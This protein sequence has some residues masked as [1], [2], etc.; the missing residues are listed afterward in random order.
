MLCY[1]YLNKNENLNHCS[2]LPRISLIPMRISTS[3]YCC[4]SMLSTCTSMWLLICLSCFKIQPWISKRCSLSPIK[5]LRQEKQLTASKEKVNNI[6]MKSGINAFL[7]H[8]PKEESANVLHPKDLFQEIH[9]S[10]FD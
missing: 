9:H 6:L 4:P 3:Y 1:Y 8:L 2:C 5:K 7:N 10:K